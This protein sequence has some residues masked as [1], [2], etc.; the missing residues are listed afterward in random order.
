MEH[1]EAESVVGL[2]LERV[3][4]RVLGLLEPCDLCL[5]GLPKDPLLVLFREM[6]ADL[7][8]VA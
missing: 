7:G 3:L 8:R 4:E 2:D 6:G 1:R 5:V